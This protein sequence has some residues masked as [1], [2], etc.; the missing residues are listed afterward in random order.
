MRLR[1][2]LLSLVTLIPSSN[3]QQRKDPEQQLWSSVKKELVSQNGFQYFR[4]NILDARLPWMRGTILSAD[5]NPQTIVVAMS[6]KTSP[7]VTLQIV[8]HAPP[9][10]WRPASLHAHVEAGDEIEFMGIG[11]DFTKEPFMVT[12]YVYLEDLRHL[13]SE[14]K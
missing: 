1:G 2:I 13:R 4:E 9:N 6:D 3:A 11:T 8:E 12:F 14:R 5:D 7:E 10:E